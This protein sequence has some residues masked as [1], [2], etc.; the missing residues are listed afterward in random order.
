[1]TTEPSATELATV[2]VLRRGLAAGLDLLVPLLLVIV[3]IRAGLFPGDLLHVP[4]TWFVTE[5]W[6]HNW[7]NH[8]AYFLWPPLILAIFYLVWVV[9]W[10]QLM[11]RTP[12]AI[13]MGIEVVD[14]SGERP[15]R[16]V[17]ALRHLASLTLVLTLGLGYLWIIASRYRLGLHDLLSG[18][19]VVVRRRSFRPPHRRRSQAS[20]GSSPV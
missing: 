13:A 14:R 9:V 15:R 8:P 20:S 2:G 18:T 5:W 1:M 17:L 6:L 19:R 4:A 7:L 10:E 3:A 12:G 16:R 11:G